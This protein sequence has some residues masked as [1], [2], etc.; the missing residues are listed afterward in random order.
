MHQWRDKW[1]VIDCVNESNHP[2]RNPLLLV[3]EP[4]TRDSNLYIIT[5][6]SKL[7]NR[8]SASV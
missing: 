4:R 5:V 3:T 8:H 2:I 7:I 6:E 1:N